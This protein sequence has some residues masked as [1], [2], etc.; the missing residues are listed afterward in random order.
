MHIAFVISFK[1]FKTHSIEPNN[2]GSLGGGG[3]SGSFILGKL[4]KSGNSGI[5]ILGKIFS[6]GR[7]RLNP[8]ESGK[9]SLGA[10]GN[11]KGLVLKSN[12][13]KLIFKLSLILCKSKTISGSF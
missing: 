11:I 4:G 7:F 8:G 10:G 13:G 5:S 9:V 2:F 1:I 6:F 12:S 3:K